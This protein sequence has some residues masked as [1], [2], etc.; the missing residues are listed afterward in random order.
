MVMKINLQFF[1]GRGGSS[2]LGKTNGSVVI[3]KRSEPNAQGYSFY[4]TGSR[5]VISNWDD[6]GNYYEKGLKKK[7]SI[8]QRFNTREEAIKYAKDNGYKY[9]NL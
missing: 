2:G 1:G 5:D 8:R 4:V 7:E 3:Q 6:D 9:L